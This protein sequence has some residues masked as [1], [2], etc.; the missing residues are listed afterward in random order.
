ML[1]YKN[2]YQNIFYIK[3]IIIILHLILYQIGVIHLIIFKH[4]I[5][6][7]WTD[8]IIILQIL[9]MLLLKIHQFSK[10][11]ILIINSIIALFYEIMVLYFLFL[12]P[13]API[14]EYLGTVDTQKLDYNF[15]GIPL[16]YSISATT[17]ALSTGIHL[18]I[19]ALSS[20][21]RDLEI[22]GLFILIGFILWSLIAIIDSLVI[23]NPQIIIILRLLLLIGTF[24]LYMGFSP[25]NWV[26]RRIWGF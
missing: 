7:T 18:S 11:Q 26:K 16:I 24:S 13:A 23:W 25:P 8:K 19:R 9:I 2:Y 22:R 1:F 17:I 21:R 6:N 12:S 3:W 4:I 15:V 14:V 5:L 20:K 10:K